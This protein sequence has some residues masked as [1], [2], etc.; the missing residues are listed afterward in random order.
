MIVAAVSSVL[1]RTALSVRLPFLPVSFLLYYHLSFF[2]PRT[3]AWLEAENAKNEAELTAGRNPRGRPSYSMSPQERER[4]K[5]SFRVGDTRFNRRTVK[6]A[7]YEFFSF[8]FFSFSFFE[9]HLLRACSF[10]SQEI[11]LSCMSVSILD[12]KYEPRAWT[13]QVCVVCFSGVFPLSSPIVFDSFSSSLF[14]FFPFSGPPLRSR[15]NLIAIESA[16]GSSGGWDDMNHDSVSTAEHCPHCPTTTSGSNIR[17]GAN[18]AVGNLL[19]TLNADTQVLHS[20]QAL[21]GQASINLGINAN[22][23]NE[24]DEDDEEEESQNQEEAAEEDETE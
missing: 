4:Y 15:P 22:H 11:L 2:R 13:L 5:G 12:Q 17:I 9:S 24:D 23:N 20:L 10:S 18:I 7:S 3:D 19:N 6:P 21:N 16:L 14:P 8:L 1:Y